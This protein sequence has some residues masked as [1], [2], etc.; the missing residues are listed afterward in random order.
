M[1]VDSQSP[2]RNPSATPTEN[3][4][5]FSDETVVRDFTNTGE[6]GSITPSSVCQSTCSPGASILS[7]VT[8][9]GDKITPRSR[10]GKSWFWSPSSGRKSSSSIAPS[11]DEFRPDTGV[12]SN[13]LAQY[14]LRQ[15]RRR[16]RRR[17]RAAVAVA[18]LLLVTALV[19]IFK[20]TELVPII[21]EMS[22]GRVARAVLPFIDERTAIGY[23]LAKPV[24]KPVTVKKKATKP[25]TTKENTSGTTSKSMPPTDVQKKEK[26]KGTAT[27]DPKQRE[28]NPKNAKSTAAALNAET[29]KIMRRRRA[30]CNIPMMY[31]FYRPCWRES[32]SLPLDM[33][34]L[35]STMQ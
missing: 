16:R 25:P 3:T 8:Y 31:L 23:G 33:S 12:A 27:V 35:D 7:D 13:S 18:L 14:R 32:R 21:N 28:T 9:D 29:E 6:G 4:S 2:S 22:G 26:P 1:R 11:A 17:K 19:F 15:K 24:G 30:I 34:F 20:G 10:S 5:L